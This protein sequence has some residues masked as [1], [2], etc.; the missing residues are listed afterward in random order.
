MPTDRQKKDRRIERRSGGRTDRETD[1]HDEANN[2][3][4][5]FHERV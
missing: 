5:Q 2:L 1:I 3:I 4:A